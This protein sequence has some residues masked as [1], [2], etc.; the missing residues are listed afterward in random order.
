VRTLIGSQLDGVA[1]C[2][3][4]ELLPIKNSAGLDD[5]GLIAIVRGCWKLKKFEV[6]GCKRI[7]GTGVKTLASLLGGEEKEEEMG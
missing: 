7:I 1:L 3:G 5:M 6:V 2:E 4:L